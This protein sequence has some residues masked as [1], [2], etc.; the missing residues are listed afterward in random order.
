[1]RRPYNMDV[2]LLAL[3]VQ[4]PAFSQDLDELS[5]E[6][7]RLE[8]LSLLNESPNA[9]ILRETRET[10]VKEHMDGARSSL[11]ANRQDPAVADQNFVSRVP[12]FRNA[13]TKYRN[14]M[15]MEPSQA[16]SL[17]ELDKFVDTFRTYFEQTHVDALPVDP[18]EFQD[19]SRKELLWETLTSAERVDTKLRQAALLVHNARV[20]NV[21]SVQAMLFLR[22]LHGELKRLDL[23]IS[24]VK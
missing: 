17:K 11:E 5:R 15:E 23:L 19:F 24:K 22:N 4:L 12:Q 2:L 10:F 3:L 21:T 8:Q 1:M 14:A 20:S 6:R 18:L 7:N 16:K 9:R 13:V